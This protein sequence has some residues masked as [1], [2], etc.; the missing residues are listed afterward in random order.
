MTWEGR[1]TTREGPKAFALVASDSVFIAE[2]TETNTFMLTG[3]VVGLYFIFN[4]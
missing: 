1:R 4:V 3:Q 2:K